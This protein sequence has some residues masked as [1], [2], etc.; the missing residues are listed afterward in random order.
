MPAAQ[1]ELQVE[2]DRVR[3]AVWR[4]GPGD[5]TGVH[6]HEYDYVVVPVTDG[7]FEISADDGTVTSFEMSAGESYFRTSGV[8]HD[9]AF[10]GEGNASFVEIELTA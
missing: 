1:S 8:R 3:V 7:Q 5:S 4:F 6:Q 10:V 9:V 2:N